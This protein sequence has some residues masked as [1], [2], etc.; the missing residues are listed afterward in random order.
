MIVVNIPAAY[1][2]VYKDDLVILELRMVLGNPKTPTPTL[3]SKVSEEI[4]Y[5]LACTV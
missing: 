4:L 5:L 3:T 1:M 2:K